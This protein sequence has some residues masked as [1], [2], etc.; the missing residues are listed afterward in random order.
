MNLIINSVFHAELTF[1]DTYIS[2]KMYHML[3][4]C[5]KN[6][7]ESY[8][9]FLYITYFSATESVCNREKCEKSL[10]RSALHS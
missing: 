9:T 7:H 3:Y 1:R 6:I 10:K 8:K 5:Y 4:I 2:L